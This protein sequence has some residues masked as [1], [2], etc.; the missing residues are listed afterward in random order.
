MQSSSVHVPCKSGSPQGVLGW[1]QFLA[2]AGVVLATGAAFAVCPSAG[3]VVSAKKAT[4]ANGTTDIR[5]GYLITTLLPG[6]EAAAG[7]YFFFRSP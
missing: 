6:S 4:A 7:C 5:I 3:W 2:A 1:V